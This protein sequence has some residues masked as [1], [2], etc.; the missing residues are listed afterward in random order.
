MNSVAIVIS[1]CD[2]FFDAWRPF[3]FFFRKFWPDCQFPVHLITNELQIQSSFIHA[4]PVG[5]DRG[6]AS[7]MKRALDEIDA[8]R[9]LYLQEDYFLNAPVRGDQVATEIAYAI[10]NDVD[11]FYFRA[12][13]Q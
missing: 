1:S 6:W 8:A 3:A 5:E 12:R 9:V 11:A 2:A 13:S 7:N 10:E 4:I